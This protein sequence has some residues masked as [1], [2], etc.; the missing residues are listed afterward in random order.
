[1]FQTQVLLTLLAATAVATL[2]LSSGNVASP[3]PGGGTAAVIRPAAELLRDMF[4]DPK[5]MM[6]F[7]DAP[8]KQSD[9][10]AD[11]ATVV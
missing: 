11:K 10:D 4:A 6:L 9:V 3:H 1:M 7:V 5:Y 2:A 8:K